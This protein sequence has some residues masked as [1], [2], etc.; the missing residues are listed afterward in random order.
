MHKIRAEVKWIRW[1]RS[2]YERH[3]I[4]F[5]FQRQKVKQMDWNYSYYPCRLPGL[6]ICVV[7]PQLYN[8]PD[9]SM[10]YS[11]MTCCFGF[12]NKGVLKSP[13][14]YDL[15]RLMTRRLRLSFIGRTW[16]WHWR[17]CLAL[18]RCS[19]V[20]SRWLSQNGCFSKQSKVVINY[21]MTYLSY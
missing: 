11:N 18:E 7:Y 16:L 1:E 10:K 6:V 2:N 21:K 8:Y 9:V 14:Y 19:T 17:D 12:V 20:T 13:I 4:A 5:Q 3:A 15:R